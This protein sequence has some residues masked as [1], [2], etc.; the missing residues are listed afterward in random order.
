MLQ[1]PNYVF[2]YAPVLRLIVV[3]LKIFMY[4][5]VEMDFEDGV[6]FIEPT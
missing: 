1:S 2:L 3:R 6:Y 5:V 4:S